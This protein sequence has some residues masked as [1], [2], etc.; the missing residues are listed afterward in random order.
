METLPKNKLSELPQIRTFKTRN[1]KIILKIQTGT[2]LALIPTLV[3]SLNPINNRIN[4]NVPPKESHLIGTQA[5]RDW[6]DEP[7]GSALL[8]PLLSISLEKIRW[9]K[10]NRVANMCARFANLGLSFQC[11]ILELRHTDEDGQLHTTE[12][13]ILPVGR[14]YTFN[15]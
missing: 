13:L 10:R 5:R 1:T 12:L 6:Q 9:H 14:I 4:T 8:R 7:P 3:S 11:S 15:D 2:E